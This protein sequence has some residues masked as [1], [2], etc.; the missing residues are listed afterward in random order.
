MSALV[1]AAV[2]ADGCIPVY[3]IGTGDV[4]DMSLQWRSKEKNSAYFNYTD[5]SNSLGGGTF[6]VAVRY[7]S[8]NN[9]IML[10]HSPSSATPK[11]NEYV[12]Y[13]KHTAGLIKYLLM[14]GQT[15]E[16]D[17]PGTVTTMAVAK[18]TETEGKNV[19]GHERESRLS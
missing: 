13:L 11:T 1:V 16:A 10:I 18:V 3:E 17:F 9:R 19:S 6:Y 8:P 2:N 15:C 7:N 4:H 14:S 12:F 5:F